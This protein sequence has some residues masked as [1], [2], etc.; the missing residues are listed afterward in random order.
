V[1]RLSKKFFKNVSH[2]WY[3]YWFFHWDRNC[4]TVNNSVAN[5]RKVLGNQIIRSLI[6]A[7]STTRVDGIWLFLCG[8]KGDFHKNKTHIHTQGTAYKKKYL[9]CS[10]SNLQTKISNSYERYDYHVSCIP[11]RCRRTYL[12]AALTS[13]VMHYVNV[14]PIREFAVL[15]AVSVLSWTLCICIYSLETKK[16]TT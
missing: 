6:L 4:S 16:F 10:I 15:W 13:Y 9:V 2:G 12:K 14:H 1:D 7:Y 8:F 11:D 3:A 5:L